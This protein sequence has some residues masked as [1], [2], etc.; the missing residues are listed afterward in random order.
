[1]KNYRKILV[2][3]QMNFELNYNSFYLVFLLKEV[4]QCFYPV[5]FQKMLLKSV[6]IDIMILQHF[7]LELKGSW[8]DD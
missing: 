7:S 6:K 2:S 5:F 3:M 1:M 4:Y 8:I